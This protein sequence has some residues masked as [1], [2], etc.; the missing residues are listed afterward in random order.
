MSLQVEFTLDTATASQ[1]AE[2]LMRCDGDFIPPLSSRTEIGNYASKVSVNAE[3]FEAWSAGALVGLVAAYC[4][5]MTRGQAFITSVS[6]EPAFRRAGIGSELLARCIAHAARLGFARIEL[7]VDSANDGAIDLY[8][9]RGFVIR[10]A[11]DRIV[12][13]SVETGRE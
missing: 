12:V 8:L 11:G 3:R 6:V 2:H 5:D 4:N 10:S 13:M 7:E 9:K 1:I